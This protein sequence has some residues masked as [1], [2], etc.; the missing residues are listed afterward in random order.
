MSGVRGGASSRCDY[1]PQTL[2]DKTS[3]RTNTSCVNSLRINTEPRRIR[4]RAFVLVLR[5]PSMTV[6]VKKCPLCDEI[7]IKRAS[8]RARCESGGKSDTVLCFQT[9]LFFCFFLKRSSITD[10]ILL[11]F[12]DLGQLKYLKKPTC[13]TRC[14]QRRREK[15][16]K[17]TQKTKARP[18][19]CGLNLL[20]CN[21]FLFGGGFSLCLMV[22]TWLKM[23]S[24]LIPAWPLRV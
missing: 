5:S 13:A 18:T 21:S 23:T 6:Q 9:G 12:T 8:G 19:G 2:S 4:L 22:F 11:Y 16:R 14:C 10:R 3:T 7:C 24:P 1:N 17:S 20:I 15:K